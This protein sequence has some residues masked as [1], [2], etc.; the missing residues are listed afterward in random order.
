MLHISTQQLVDKLWMRLWLGSPSLNI[1]IAS[2]IKDGTCVV[3]TDGSYMR[4]LF[5]KTHLAAFVFKCSKG[6]GRLWG[7]FPETSRSSCSY[8]GELVGLM[9]IHLILHSDNK[10]NIKLKGA[11][12]IY[13]DCMGALNDVKISHHH[14][15]QQKLVTWMSSRISS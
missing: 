5:P 9:A 7:S 11:V 1:K 2:A 6:Y 8:T 3:V 15:S 10:V 4:K 14:E 13:S 12:Q